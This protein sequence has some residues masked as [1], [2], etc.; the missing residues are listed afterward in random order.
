[1]EGIHQFRIA[2]KRVRAVVR[3][4]ELEQSSTNNP[5]KKIKRL[6]QKLGDIRSLQILYEVIENYYKDNGMESRV[7][8]L[9]LSKRILREKSKY[10]VLEKQISFDKF[11][12]DLE[13]YTLVKPHNEPIRNYIITQ[14]EALNENLNHPTDEGIHLMRKILKDFQYNAKLLQ[15]IK[16]IEIPILE[17]VQRLKEVTDLLGNYNDLRTSRMYLRSLSYQIPQEEQKILSRLK[18]EW[19]KKKK[20]QKE[21][22]LNCIKVLVFNNG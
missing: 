13:R 17:N 15:T 9:K 5:L 7:Y 16:G 10:V 12:E 20:L 18:V 14:I 4:I 19:L 11:H 22:V 6:Y 2:Y 8:L 1:L 3:M 21:K